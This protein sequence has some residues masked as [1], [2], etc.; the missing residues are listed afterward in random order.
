MEDE[1][2]RVEP[3][4]QWHVLHV[5]S[6]HEKKVAIHLIHHS[7]EHFLPLYPE[8][9]RWSD[10]SVT[11]E[12]PL[13]PGYI[14]VRFAREAR[15]TVI[16]L[17][18]ALKVLGKGGSDVVEAAEIER[19]RAGLASGCILRPHPAVTVG[20]RVRVRSGIFAGLE[21]MVLELRSSCKV[22]ILMSAVRQCYSLETEMRNI[23]I[24]DKKVICAASEAPLDNRYQ[25]RR[26]TARD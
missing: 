2:L 12:R 23:E 1:F 24:M 22:V 21:G 3:P 25:A 16:S 15:R 4:P 17:P 26:G 6:N 18:G 14:F 10:R 11:L 19:I 20:T 8:R 5:A 13:F 9:S 7:V